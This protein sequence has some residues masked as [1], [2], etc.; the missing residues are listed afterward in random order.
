MVKVWH[1][2][3]SLIK[4][5]VAIQSSDKLSNKAEKATWYINICPQAGYT[6]TIKTEE[7]LKELWKENFCAWRKGDV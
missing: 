7:Q 1:P 4:T 3:Y 5:S 2:N 6:R